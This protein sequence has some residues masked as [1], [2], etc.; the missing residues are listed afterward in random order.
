M[1]NTKNFLPLTAAGL[2]AFS[3]LAAEEKQSQSEPKAPAQQ[4]VVTTHVI[5]I[6]NGTEKDTFV[7][8]SIKDLQT[9]SNFVDSFGEKQKTTEREQA[10]R[11]AFHKYTAD[12]NAKEW[13][14]TSYLIAAKTAQIAN[15]LSK[16]AVA[17]ETE[18]PFFQYKTLLSPLSAK[19]LHLPKEMAAYKL[20]P[21]EEARVRV[22]FAAGI[23]QLNSYAMKQPVETL[24]SLYASAAKEWAKYYQTLRNEYTKQ[25]Q[26]MLRDIMQYQY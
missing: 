25:I 6:N 15:D 9:L 14:A 3:A 20:T 11:S 22:A 21:V 13:M 16:A 19:T 23:N 17:S 5:Y 18:K 10:E 26:P 8:D 24:P 7:Q 12:F 2:M 1:I 4:R